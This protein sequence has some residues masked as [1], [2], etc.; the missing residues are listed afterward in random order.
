MRLLVGALIVC[1]AVVPAVVRA[2]RVVDASGRPTLAPSFKK[3][4]DEPPSAADIPGE[5]QVTG[6]AVVECR[7]VSPGAPVARTRSLRTPD[8]LRGPPAAV[9]S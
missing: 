8:T 9:R 3:S 4:F 1:L 7:P 2:T 5:I 6:L